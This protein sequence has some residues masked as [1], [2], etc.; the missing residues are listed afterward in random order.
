MKE[1]HVV[2]PKDRTGGAAGG[3]VTTSFIG[4]IRPS[5]T[6]PTSPVSAAD[7]PGLHGGSGLNSVFGNSNGGA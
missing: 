7:C 2:A 3:T 5:S 6:G 1:S 4:E